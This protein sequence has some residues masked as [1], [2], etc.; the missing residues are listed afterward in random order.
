MS[1][2]YAWPEGEIW[3][4]TGAAAASAEPSL[5]QNLD[6]TLTRAAQNRKAASGNYF[7]VQTGLI[8]NV[9][10]GG[11]V[12]HNFTEQKIFESATAVH[13]KLMQSSV[14][15]TAGYILY[16]GWID[17]LQQA[18]GEGELFLSTLTYHANDWTAFGGTS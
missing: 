12:S 14:N 17:S 8:A 2:A 1:E 9:R 18:A 10:I 13:M 16:S 3:L 7:N 5:A 4:W 6:F 11:M 15:G